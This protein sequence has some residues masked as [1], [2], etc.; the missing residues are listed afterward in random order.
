[1]NNTQRYFT[2]TIVG[3]PQ[4]LV[5]GQQVRFD[6]DPVLP[7]SNAPEIMVRWFAGVRALIAERLREMGNSVS[8]RQVVSEPPLTTMPKTNSRGW[9]FWTAAIGV[10][11]LIGTGVVVGLSTTWVQEY[12][13]KPERQKAAQSVEAADSIHAPA[14]EA[15][16]PLSSAPVSAPSN[17]LGV[18]TVIDEPANIPNAP[19]PTAPAIDSAEKSAAAKPVQTPFT[20]VPRQVVEK[21]KETVKLSPAKLTPAAAS[22]VP[23]Q[24]AEK[25]KEEEQ[26]SAVVIDVLKPEEVQKPANAK[27]AK[28]AHEDTPSAVTRHFPVPTE[29]K[30]AKA[31]SDVKAPKSSVKR[32]TVVD[33]A[34]DGTYALVTNPDTKLPQKFKVGDKIYTGETI[35]KIEPKS[36]KLVLDAR[37]VYME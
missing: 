15:A 37:T 1:M 36:G 5:L 4:R 28:T 11:V 3:K 35:Q 29:I 21:S 32:V 2:Q 17:T 20:P 10:P 6:T 13:Q 16:L 34:P 9:A 33:I 18:I 27:P 31:E 14:H 23:R 26:K 8:L 30:S 12:K 7:G 24:G 19:E 22:P 25:Q